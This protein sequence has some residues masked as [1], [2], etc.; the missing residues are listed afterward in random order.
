[1][2]LKQRPLC[3]Y[4]MVSRLGDTDWRNGAMVFWLRQEL[5][6]LEAMGLT[7]RIDRVISRVS[8]VQ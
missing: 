7:L 4:G 6:L 2:Q 5:E 8:F 1:M 3:L